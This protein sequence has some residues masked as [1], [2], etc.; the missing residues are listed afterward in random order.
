MEGRGVREKKEFRGE[1][2]F[3]RLLRAY[4]R[5]KMKNPR[6]HITFSVGKI[7][8][9][10]LDFKNREKVEPSKENSQGGGGEKNRIKGRK[11]WGQ[12]PLP[13]SKRTEKACSEE[14]EKDLDQKGS[15]DFEELEA[16]FKKK[17]VPF[18]GI[19][20]EVKLAGSTGVSG[21]RSYLNTLEGRKRR[22]GKGT[23]SFR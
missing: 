7:R 17:T 22:G 1:R 8:E 2:S 23:Q 12:V 10:R 15:W 9:C 20:E 5:P 11:K 19:R 4:S 6:K 14:K 21:N 3:A 13:R 16:L 18:G